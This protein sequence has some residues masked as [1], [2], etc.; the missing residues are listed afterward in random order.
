M[1]ATISYSRCKQ[2]LVNIGKASSHIRSEE[3]EMNAAKPN[4]HAVYT[5]VEEPKEDNRQEKVHTNIVKQ[6]KRERRG[7]ERES[8]CKNNKQ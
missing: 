2:S 7:W 5:R 4:T 8:R 1:A 3:H 6:R